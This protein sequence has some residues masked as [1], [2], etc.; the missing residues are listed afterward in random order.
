MPNY[1]SRLLYPREEPQYQ[2]NRWLGGPQS[3]SG[4]SGEVKHLLP[5]LGIKLQIVQTIVA[6]IL[7]ELYWLS[8]HGKWENTFLEP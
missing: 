7:T 1:S 3:W 5:L 6:T 8:A 4:H 2:L